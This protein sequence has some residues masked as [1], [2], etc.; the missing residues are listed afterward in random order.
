MQK[1][2]NAIKSKSSEILG[3][4][5]MKSSDRLTFLAE[6]D[7]VPEDA[8]IVRVSGN[9]A[10]KGCV[11]WQDHQCILPSIFLN[12]IQENIVANQEKCQIKHECVWYA[13]EGEK[14]CL[15]CP[16]IFTIQDQIYKLSEIQR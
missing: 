6:T 2:P 5:T 3:F 14:I 13:Q 4:R 10:K 9:C 8:D 1:C 16:L 11:N 12:K 15:K 7:I